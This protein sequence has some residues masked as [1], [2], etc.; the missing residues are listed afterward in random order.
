MNFSGAVIGTG[1]KN[2]GVYIDHVARKEDAKP[3]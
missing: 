3:Q 1:V 2:V